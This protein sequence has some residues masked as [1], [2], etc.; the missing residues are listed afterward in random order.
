MISKLAPFQYYT[1]SVDDLFPERKQKMAENNEKK[2]K[3]PK[4]QWS[5]E[6]TLKYVEKLRK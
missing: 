2:V 3:L 5:R 4:K 6:E 1:V